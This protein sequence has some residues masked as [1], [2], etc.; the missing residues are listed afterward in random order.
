MVGAV[1]PL[2][3]S[4]PSFIPS[5]IGWLPTS[6]CPFSFFLIS[7]APKIDADLTEK[8][9]WMPLHCPF[10]QTKRSSSSA[11]ALISPSYSS[12]FLNVPILLSL[13]S[14]SS[15]SPIQSFQKPLVGHL[16]NSC[17]CSSATA[18]NGKAKHASPVSMV[19]KILDLLM[20]FP[21]RFW[22]HGSK[23]PCKSLP[24]NCTFWNKCPCNHDLLIVWKINQPAFELSFGGIFLGTN[25]VQKS[26]VAV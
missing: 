5:G 24:Y 11:M 25:W 19:S 9:V 2:M 21:L 22:I 20:V 6:Q 13:T 14:A 4:R 15:L 18:K 12:L 3:N 16:G 26:Q 23:L 1:W 7:S 8:K 10:L 17:L